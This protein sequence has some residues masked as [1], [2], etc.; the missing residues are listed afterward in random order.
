MATVYRF[1][2]KKK[3][4]VWFVESHYEMFFHDPQ[5]LVCMCVC[6]R[7]HGVSLYEGHRET[8][9]HA[10]INVHTCTLTYLRVCVC[11]RAHICVC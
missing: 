1:Q 10:D 2:K 9:I 4:L 8:H 3:G 6:A 11:A 7:Q 5:L